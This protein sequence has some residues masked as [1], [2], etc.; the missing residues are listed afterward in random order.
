MSTGQFS[1]SQIKPKISGFWLG[2]LILSPQPIILSSIFYL[3][4]QK[5]SVVPSSN[6]IKLQVE[7][8]QQSHLPPGGLRGKVHGHLHE[9]CGGDL[10]RILIRF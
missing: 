9:V 5:I 2:T 8:G 3:L 1:Y 4:I 6:R 7:Q 10:W